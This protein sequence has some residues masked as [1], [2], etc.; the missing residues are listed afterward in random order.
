M[1]LTDGGKQRDTHEADSARLARNG[2]VRVEGDHCY[3]KEEIE[4]EKK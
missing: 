4:G 3:R 1:G 2:A